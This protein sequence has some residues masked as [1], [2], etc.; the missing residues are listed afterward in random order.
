MLSRSLEKARKA[1]EKKDLNA[2]IQ[3]HT[4]RAP[5]VH[6]MEKGKYVKS[7]IY[8]GMDGIITTFAVVAGVAGASLQTSIVLIMGFANL[9]A[10]GISMAIGD[11]LSTKSEQEYQKNERKRETWEVENYPEGEKKEMKEIYM[12]K[13]FSEDDSEKMV[14]ILS[15]NKKAWIDEMM[16][17]E[18]NIIESQEKPLKNAV[19]TF[20][21][22]AVFGF[23]PLLAY[24]CAKFLGLF[25]NYTFAA[26]CL[27]TGITLF[28]LG[29]L[30][31]NVTGRNWVKSGFETL[32]VGGIAAGAAYL[33]GYAIASIV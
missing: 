28:I 20:I 23:V 32:L 8:G 10:D 14:E 6:Q 29:A 11:Y 21:S 24:V 22:F 2:T 5:E 1:F 26:A 30:K 27:F 9:V 31:V 12:E 3:A 16:H 33:V 25:E 19:A 18:L 7:V 4:Q 17:D 13:G 15:K